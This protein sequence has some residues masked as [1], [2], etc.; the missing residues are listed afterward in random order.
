MDDMKRIHLV[1]AFL[2]GMAALLLAAAGWHGDAKAGTERDSTVFRQ[3]TKPPVVTHKGVEWCGGGE[4]RRQDARI[5]GISD[6]Q[7]EGNHWMGLA[8]RAEMVEGTLIFSRNKNKSLYLE[9][10]SDVTAHDLLDAKGGKLAMRMRDSEGL[11]TA[12]QTG[13]YW[14]SFERKHRLQRFERNGEGWRAVGDAVPVPLNGKGQDG[15]LGIETIIN[16]GDGTWWLVAEYAAYKDKG[17]NAVKDASTLWIFD[18]K[19]LTE[20][21]P[22]QES[23]GFMPTSVARWD[24]MHLLVLERKLTLFEGFRSRLRLVEIGH[25]DVV[26]PVIEVTN[27]IMHDN[28]E[29]LAVLDSK[30]GEKMVLIG[31]DDNFQLWQ[32]SWLVGLCM[33]DEAFAPAD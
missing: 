11:A 22:Y 8:D 3:I 15:N 21:R 2:L 27:Y 1:F 26:G 4:I 30:E 29:D 33:T 18:G 28:A 9:D 19:A 24:E 5:G 31:S 16:L 6:M 14:V 32:S 10:L 7:V 23:E 25:E 12:E 20:S 13:E 17:G